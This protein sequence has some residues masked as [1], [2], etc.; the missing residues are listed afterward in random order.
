MTLGEYIKQQREKRNLSQREFARRAGLSNVAIARIE[1]GSVI[2]PAETTLTSIATA[3]GVEPVRLYRLIGYTPPAHMVA[4]TDVP[5][6]SDLATQLFQDASREGKTLSDYIREL[7]L[8]AEYGKDYI[9]ERNEE[10]AK[11][12]EE[13]EAEE[14]QAKQAKDKD[15]PSAEEPK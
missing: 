2:H 10:F 11:L 13:I 14:E 9:N 6:D 7:Q 1:D 15:E 8:F 3:L 5:I 12:G 4:V